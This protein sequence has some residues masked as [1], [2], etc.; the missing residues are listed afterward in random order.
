MSEQRAMFCMALMLLAGFCL[1][2]AYSLNIEARRLDRQADYL[3][4]SLDSHAVTALVIP[5]N[6]SKTP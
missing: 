6:A 4:A 1:G 2:R 5:P 3:R